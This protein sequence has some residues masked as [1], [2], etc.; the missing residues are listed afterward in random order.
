MLRWPKPVFLCL[1]LVAVT[2]ATAC[3]EEGASPKATPTPTPEAPPTP[4]PPVEG[5]IFGQVLY[6]NGSP[7]DPD[8]HPLL[9]AEV[10][11]CPQGID[12]DD[13][14]CTLKDASDDG[15][16]SFLDVAPGDYTVYVICGAC[17][18]RGPS[19]DKDVH[20]EPGQQPSV[21]ITLP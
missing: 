12:W 1:A 18:V 8:Q 19:A 17:F 9:C 6:S 11:L 15:T 16:F 10:S 4:T 20:L 5:D 13:A 7:C 21:T 3:G 14:S 2:H